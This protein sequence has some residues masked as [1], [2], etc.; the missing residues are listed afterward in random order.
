MVVAGLIMVI[1][2]TIGTGLFKGE[3]YFCTAGAS[4]TPTSFTGINTK[5]VNLFFFQNLN[6]P[7]LIGMSDCR[8]NMG[9]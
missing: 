8:R 4:G 2:A 6:Q 9:K 1:G 3:F 5:N 7:L